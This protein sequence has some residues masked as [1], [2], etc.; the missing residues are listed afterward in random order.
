MCVSQISINVFDCVC[1]CLSVCVSVCVSVSLSL[2]LSVCMYVCVCVRRKRLRND[3][4][5]EEKQM[6][7]E[8][9]TGI[10]EALICLLGILKGLY[11]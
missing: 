7:R 2:S 1:V 11:E 3:D 4:D 10:S 5:G 9:R 6:W 8:Q